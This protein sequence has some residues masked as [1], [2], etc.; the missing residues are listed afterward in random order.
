MVLLKQNGIRGV[1]AATGALGLVLW[2]GLRTSALVETLVG[3]TGYVAAI[4]LLTA[5]IRRRRLAT[6]LVVAL[7]GVAD[8]LVLAVLSHALVDQLSPS[9]M[10]LAAAMPFQLVLF[11]A[12]SAPAVAVAAV[13]VASALLHPVGDAPGDL[14]TRIASLS[15]Y[16]LFAVMSH[17]LHRNAERR[18]AALATLFAEAREGN[19]TRGY[20]VDA[21]PHGDAIT[22]VGAAFNG[23][24]AE[25]APMVHADP[26]T[27]CLNRRGFALELERALVGARARRGE[28]ALLA[29]DLDHFKQINDRFGHLVGDEVLYD[30]AALLVDA[31]GTEGVVARMGGE[32]FT[33][34]L[35][36]ADAEGAGAVAE[37]MMSRLRSH[38][39]ASLP[40]STPVTMSIGI[41]SEPVTSIEVGAALRARADEALYAAKRSGRNR[42][43]LWAPGV[44]SNA[45]PPTSMAAIQRRS[46]DVQRPRYRT[47]SEP[48][49]SHRV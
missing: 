19:F 23:L 36:K 40:V 49:P 31:V 22:A 20:D 43:L 21:D 24:R 41:A 47:P 17:R 12:G 4:G 15:G 37:R 48:A 39:C 25:L 5:W 27:G 1:L 7:H 2:P 34:L 16:L 18:L 26:A 35:T 46:G 28:I 3:L 29:I 8:V 45:T 10:L 6:G 30:V 38:V 9:W 14:A 33:A 11:Q 13:T 42:V 32:E 44:R